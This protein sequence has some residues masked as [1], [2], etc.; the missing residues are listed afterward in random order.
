MAYADIQNKVG[1][2]Q[3]ANRILLAQGTSDDQED[4]QEM[5]DEEKNE[6]KR[7]QIRDEVI[8]IKFYS[9]PILE[10]SLLY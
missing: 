10:P 9:I 7:K 2:I 4:D 8:H 3:M 5:T 1:Q 6:L